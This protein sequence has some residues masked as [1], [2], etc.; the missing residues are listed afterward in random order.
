MRHSIV[1]IAVALALGMAAGPSGDALAQS[2][3]GSGAK[4]P[5]VSK[6]VA[7]TLIAAQTAM[8]AKKFPECVAKAREADVAAGKTDFDDFQINQILSFCAIRL[9]DYGTA[10]KALEQSLNSPH[11]PQ[12]EVPQRVRALSQVNYQ[13]KNYG[14]AIEYGNRAIKGG[15]ADADMYTLVGQAY[16]IQNDYKTTQKFVGDWVSDMEKRGQKPREGALQLLLSS[17]LKLDDGTCVTRS[18]ERLVANYPKD[19]YWQNLM[20][21]LLGSGATDKVMLNIYRLAAEVNAIRRGSDYTEMAQIALDQGSPGEA[22]AALEQAIGKKLFT[23][24]RDIDR[25]NRLLAA[26]KTRATEDRATLAKQ[27]KEALADKANGELDVK[28]GQAYLSYGQYPQAVA[29][30]SRGITEG[31]LKNPAEAQLLLG[32]SQLR[33]GNK[34]EAEKAFKAAKGDDVLTRLGALWALRAQ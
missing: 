12:D 14:K 15:F 25:N 9:N 1:G 3:G 22:Q 16:Y 2:S 23:E 10:A 29:A 33:A 11:M 5:S 4:G 32:I 18:L 20:Q 13:L 27:D 30:I 8:N 19:E 34:A 31:K 24:Q 21:S 7:K 26:A 28:L 6:A 17:C